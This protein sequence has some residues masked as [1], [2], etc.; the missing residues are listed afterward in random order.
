MEAK[1]ALYA[2][3]EVME[4]SVGDILIEAD[5]PNANLFVLLEGAS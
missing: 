4:C 5:A 2:I 1:T 3:G